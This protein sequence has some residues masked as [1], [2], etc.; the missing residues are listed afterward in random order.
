MYIADPIETAKIAP[1]RPHPLERFHGSPAGTA[2]R[3]RTGGAVAAALAA[4]LLVLADAPLSPAPA[5]VTCDDAW[6]RGT[7]DASGRWTTGAGNDYRIGCTAD[8]DGDAMTAADGPDDIPANADTLVIDVSHPN[9]DR[10]V[11]IIPDAEGGRLALTGNLASDAGS[12]VFIRIDGF[13]AGYEAADAVL[14]SFATIEASGD[15]NDGIVL[16]NNDASHTGTIEAINR[17][18]IST[19]GDMFAYG[20]L[21]FSES[22]SARAV[23]AGTITTGGTAG[24]GVTT[25]VE[26]GSAGTAT[27]I[28]RGTVRTSGGV[29]QTC[30]GNFFVPSDGVRAYH[31]DNGNAE[32][33][34]AAGG[35]I[36]VAGIGG[37]GVSAHA[38]GDGSAVAGNAGS[39]VTR[40]DAFVYPSNDGWIGPYG[41]LA[42]SERGSATAR[43]S[44]SGSVET[45]GVPGY[46]VVA[47]SRGSGTA[48]VENAGAVVTHATGSIDTLP[49]NVG[50]EIGA[51]GLFAT[52][53]RGDASVVNQRSG[54]VETRGAR[55]F[56]AIAWTSNDGS[57]R[58]ATATIRNRGRVA[59]GGDNADAVIALSTSRATADNPNT[60]RAY[61]EDGG[62]ITTTG[63]AASGLGAAILVARGGQGYGSAFAQNAGTIATEGARGGVTGTDIAFG[64]TASFFNNDGGLIT[65]A[66]DVEARNTGSIEVSGEAAQGIQARTFGSGRATVVVDGGRV[67]ATHDSATDADDGVGIHASSGAAGSIAV[68]LDNRALVQA[69]QAMLLGDAPATVTVMRSSV[70]RGRMSFGGSADSLKIDNSVT[71]GDIATGGG[72]DVIRAYG[73]VTMTGDIDFGAGE[74]ELILDVSGASR[75]TGNI[76]NLETLNKLC[77]GDF[78]I[79]GDI[80][81]A[82][83]SVVVSEGGLVLT[84][85]MNVGADGTVEVHDGTRLTALLTATGTPRITAG[86]GTTVRD[87][88]AV[89]VEAAADARP[90]EAAEAVATFLEGANVQGG[91]ALP[92]QTRDSGGSLTR[93]AS[94]D[95]ATGTAT[96]MQGAS[97]GARP[98]ERFPEQP[99]VSPTPTPD[100][101]PTPPAPTPPVSGGGGGGDDNTAL[102]IGG[103]AILA[104]LFAVL[105]WDTEAP[106]SSA[107]LNP[108]LVQPLDRSSRYWVRSLSRVMPESGAGAASGTEIGMD[109]ALGD[110]FVLG[111][112]AAPDAALE[113]AGA[114]AHATALSGGRYALKGGWQSETLFG[115]LSLSQARWRVASAYRNPTLGGGLRS[116]YEAAQSDVKLGLGARL[117]LGAGL[118]LTP[119]AGAFAGELRHES[120]TAEGPVFRAA[121]PE[122]VQRY[123]G[124]RMGL[125]LA[126]DWQ[127]GPGDLK[128]RPSLKLGAARIW[129]DSPEFALRQSDRLGIV[130][131]AS[132]A[133]LPGAPGTVLG[134]GT[135]LD[136][137]GPH[138]LSLGLRYGGLAM[139]GKLVHAAFARAKLSF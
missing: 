5:A 54:S 102:L 8:T 48:S 24:R 70:V 17:G 6:T 81:F 139:D 86:G 14:E 90:V 85:H 29:C 91:E 82:G 116:R 109:F 73:A 23:N 1:E 76:T 126:S 19:T 64:I 125:D 83:S 122:V 36:A 89:V 7:L 62:T 130:S 133:R 43:S 87:G 33:S 123:G 131:T 88:G 47:I 46:G 20:M 61:N 28:N 38:N 55:A 129:T 31:N 115:A 37:R 95:P 75:L 136:A 67:V 101:E 2:A 22:S 100:P 98:A 45:Y 71:V 138:G 94:F 78:T 27:S 9:I 10:V 30:G 113:R 108:A 34:N 124:W 127:D 104:A 60:V 49:N 11:Q 97:V 111:F 32:A 59:T 106:A 50:L 41:V 107:S 26:S 80:T 25:H 84:G 68:T 103:G 110:G 121:M 66:G 18:T 21:V 15:G 128:L 77:P 40:G 99:G 114:G 117:D 69:P 39:V 13:T 53:W 105:D 74:D 79:N 42:W 16:R 118:T 65:R 137:V 35:T 96:V 4:G 120:H 63:D 52:S 56:G 92:V 57:A 58:S 132:R 134:L 135:G 3:C 51:R 44:A 93:L 119:L 112:A 72:D 12:N